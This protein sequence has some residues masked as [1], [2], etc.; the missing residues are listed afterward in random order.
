MEHMWEEL[1]P[2]YDLIYSRKS[3]KKEAKRILNLIRRFKKSPGRELLDV[4]C[5]TG[6]HVRYLRRYFQVTGTDM[7]NHMLTMARRNSPGIRFIQQDMTELNLDKQFDVIV[8]L[9]AAIAY[10]RTY[11][12]LAKTIGRFARHLRPGGIAIIDP[13]V[14]PRQFKR[15]H[16][17]GLYFDRPGLILCRIVKSKLQG[18]IAT[19]DCH[20]LLAT[21]DG[22]R[23]SH[24]PHRIGCFD[25]QKVVRI[26]REAGLTS[27]YLSRGLMPG[28]GLFV[29]V[30]PTEKRRYRGR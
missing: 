29:G 18:N 25:E 24:D 10:T 2:Y 16:F 9:F 7:S 11:T 27:R 20:F 8:C 12:R 22:V 3:Y 21:K 1:A 23:Y 30:K 26:L 13:F 17:E 4:G 5:G 28:R 15:N 14:G 6:G 19:L